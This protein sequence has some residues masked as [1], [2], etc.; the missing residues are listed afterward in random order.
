MPIVTEPVE[1]KLTETPLESLGPLETKVVQCLVSRSKEVSLGKTIFLPF[2]AEDGRRM[3]SA[4][5]HGLATSIRSEREREREEERVDVLL[6][7]SSSGWD[8]QYPRESG[9]SRILH[10]LRSFQSPSGRMGENRS[11]EFERISSS[12]VLFV[13]VESELSGNVDQHSVVSGDVLEHGE[14]QRTSL[15]KHHDLLSLR[16][17]RNAE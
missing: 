8:R 14:Q 17:C 13:D 4:G 3:S 16:R 5:L 10:S 6:F 2:L 7:C 9:C 1:T 11:S 15:R 12:L